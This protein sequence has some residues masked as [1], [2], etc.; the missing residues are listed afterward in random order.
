MTCYKNCKKDCKCDSSSSSSSC[1]SSSSS[2]S[3]CSSSSSSS[4]ECECYIN[5][6][7]AKELLDKWQCSFPDAIILPKIGYPS[8]SCG[9]VTITHT[10][11][12]KD[13]K[14]NG[15][16]SKSPLT[17]AA[18]YSAEC[19]DDKYINLYEVGLP[20]IPGKC[21]EDST[22]QY[23]IK[24]LAKCHIEPSAIHTHWLGTKVYT[25]DHGLIYV[26]IQEIG[27]HPHEFTHKVTKALKKTVELIKCR[28]KECCKYD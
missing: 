4:S 19:S 25:C 2:S 21:G 28:A 20:D 14:L 5:D 1:S 15:L 27:L 7:R 23:F 24:K 10:L 22:V 26:H 18:L 17:N 11:C 8:H 13:V 16:K 12:L 3:S 6:C 9:V